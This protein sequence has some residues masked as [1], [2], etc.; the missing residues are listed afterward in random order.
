MFV[1]NNNLVWKLQFYCVGLFVETWISS[2][3]VCYYCFHHFDTFTKSTFQG[4]SLSSMVNVSCEKKL[5]SMFKTVLLRKNTFSLTLVFMQALS[6]SN[7]STAC[8]IRSA[9]AYW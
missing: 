9:F 1:R 5:A 6:Q 2:G 7:I 3:V 8:L 4:G